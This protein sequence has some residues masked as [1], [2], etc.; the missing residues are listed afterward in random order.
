MLSFTI[1]DL[2]IN[3]NPG[4]AFAYSMKALYFF[5]NGDME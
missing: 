4:D 2:L 3:I 1:T 5:E